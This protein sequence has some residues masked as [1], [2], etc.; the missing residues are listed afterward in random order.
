MVRV[1]GFMAHLLCDCVGVF[2]C[3]CVVRRVVCCYG[4]VSNSFCMVGCD[5]VWLF[6]YIVVR[7]CVCT[8]VRLYGGVIMWLRGCAIELM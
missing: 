5:F 6:G 4:C 1:C 7:L 3:H 8:V 2:L